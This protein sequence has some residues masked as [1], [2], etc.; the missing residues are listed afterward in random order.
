MILRIA[1][2]L[3]KSTYSAYVSMGNKE[4]IP[5]DETG[6]YKTVQAR[7]TDTIKYNVTRKVGHV[8]AYRPHNELVD[9]VSCSEE[10]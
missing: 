6:L 7:H 4:H 8:L 1:V 10:R 3:N 2:R 9:K 5:G